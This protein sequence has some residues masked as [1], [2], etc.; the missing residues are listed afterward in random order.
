MIA[1]PVEELDGSVCGLLAAS[2]LK[3]REANA[4]LLQSL[5]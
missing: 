5:A 1:V 2:N 4:A 3:V